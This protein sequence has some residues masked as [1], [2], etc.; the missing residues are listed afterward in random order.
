[1]DEIAAIRK[2]RFIEY[3]SVPRARW[4]EASELTANPASN[5]KAI[6][7]TRATSDLIGC[8]HKI[9]SAEEAHAIPAVAKKISHLVSE[10]LATGKIEI[11]SE[12]DEDAVGAGANSEA[13]RGEA[14]GSWTEGKGG[15]GEGSWGR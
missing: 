2:A 12:W 9:E 4:K 3:G 5:P 6:S 11:A 10:F 8:P 13:R 1:M 15:A 7:Y 14:G